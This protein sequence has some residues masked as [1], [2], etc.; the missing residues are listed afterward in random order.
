M[1]P[2]RSCDGQD[3]ESYVHRIGRTGRAGNEG[4]AFSLI[5]DRDIDSLSR[6]EEYTKKKIDVDFMEDADL[7]KE[8]KSLSRDEG[9][10]K[11]KFD[12][13]RRDGGQSRSRSDRPERGGDRG[14]PPRHDKPEDKGGYVPGGKAKLLNDGLPVQSNKPQRPPQNAKGQGPKPSRGPKPNGAQPTA[15]Q[16]AQAPR[17]NNSNRPARNFRSNTG[18]GGYKPTPKPAANVSIGQKVKS[19]IQKIFG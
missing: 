17:A 7:V 15:A 11:K 10:Y 9:G 16:Q 18:G 6:V 13:P 8:F 3:A 2:A 1:V 12:S 5:C 14:R 4:K 19:F